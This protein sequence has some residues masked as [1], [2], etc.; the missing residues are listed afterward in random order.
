MQSERGRFA[1]SARSQNEWERFARRA[2]WSLKGEPNAS[3]FFTV[4]ARST[5]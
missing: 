3:N 2:N 4:S 1:R 5:L